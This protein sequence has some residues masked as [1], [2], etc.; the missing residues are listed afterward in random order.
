MRSLVCGVMVLAVVGCATASA[1]APAATPTPGT[2]IGMQVPPGTTAPIRGNVS[3]IESMD[4]LQ[5]TQLELAYVGDQQHPFA[6]T[7]AD[8]RGEF[9]FPTIELGDYMLH[10]VRPG[11]TDVR[12]RVEHRTL[13]PRPLF[14]KLRSLRQRCPTGRYK[15]A[16]CP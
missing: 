7:A 13:E 14:L 11:Y 5:G 4:L 1:P 6:V 3:D 9:I 10:I 8:A 2:P 15:T 12:M 16:E